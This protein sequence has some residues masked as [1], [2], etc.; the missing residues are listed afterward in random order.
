[1]G[2]WYSVQCTVYLLRIYGGLR[3][4][5]CRWMDVIY[6]ESRRKG[7]ALCNWVDVDPRGGFPCHVMETKTRRLWDNAVKLAAATGLLAF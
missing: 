6:P 3:G 1:M 7:W 4:T 2:C 5:I